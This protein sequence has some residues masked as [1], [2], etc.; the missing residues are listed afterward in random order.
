M[1]QEL[2]TRPVPEGYDAG[3]YRSMPW[4][5]NHTS[6][7]R[8]HMQCRWINKHKAVGRVSAGGVET[9]RGRMESHVGR[10]RPQPRLRDSCRGPSKQSYCSLNTNPVHHYAVH[11]Q[12]FDWDSYH[13]IQLGLY[14]WPGYVTGSGIDLTHIHAHNLLLLFSCTKTWSPGEILHFI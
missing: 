2:G 14:C 6:Q 5:T 13:R 9:D 12:G 10:E 4:G 1:S 3:E 8:V 11:L 7:W